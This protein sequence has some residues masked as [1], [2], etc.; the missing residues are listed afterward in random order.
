M[1]NNGKQTRND[2]E[3]DYYEKIC[4]SKQEKPFHEIILRIGNK[5][6]M[7]TKTEDGQLEIKIFDEYMQD[8]QRSNP[9]LRMFSA[10]LHMDEAMSRLHIDIVL[11]TTG[12]KSAIK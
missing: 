2:R 1:Y 4:S 3:I 11:Y 5:D 7:G 9:T 6:D 8:F 12:N 10:H